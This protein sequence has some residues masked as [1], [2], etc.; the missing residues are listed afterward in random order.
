MQN[1]PDA[2]FQT[3]TDVFY[4]NFNA[5]ERTVIN[6]GGTSS[7]KT[8]S[9][10]QVLAR[11]AIFEKSVITVVGQDLPN[12]KKGAMRDFERIVQNSPILDAHITKHN[13]SEHTYTFINGSLIEFTSYKDEQDARSGK[14]DYL[15]INECNGVP[16]EIYEALQVRTNKQI[17]LDYNATGAFW[18]H[19][20]VIGKPDA[21]RFVSNYT[22]NKYISEAVRR[23]IES[24]KFNSPYR[25]RVF[26]MGLTG[27]TDDEKWL[28]SFNRNKH[29]KPV[30]YNPNEPVYI[31]IDFNV[32]KFV[33][34]AFQCSDVDNNKYSYFHVI[35]EFVLRDANIEQMSMQIKQ[36]YPANRIF[37]TGD[38]TGARQDTGYSKSNDTLLT[39]LQ[40]SLGV[41]NG[42]MLFGSYS[43]RYP[44]SNPS[45]Q[46]SWA[47]CNMCFA[48]HRN[49]FIHPDC[50][51]LIADC[52]RAKF[53]RKK[54]GFVLHKGD[55]AGDWAMNAFDCLR[56]AINIKLP[57][58]QNIAT[59]ANAMPGQ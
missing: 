37:I 52:E 19:E 45:F 18:V 32:G 48:H 38:Q 41:N 5:S 1:T 36:T 22:H 13:L 26:G 42:Q 11:K 47:H 23:Q 40:R 14:R 27:I 17:F 29:L 50:R 51:E 6:Q 44:A 49:L 2:I 21:I 43:K 53:D 46:N 8:Y 59:L 34:I 9:I 28:H 30:T 12:L 31:S 54:G 55:G 4:W 15:F 57:S 56:Y 20:Q 35:K 24:Y 10:L 25:W 16:F 3:V 33:A 39:I 7:S 58:F